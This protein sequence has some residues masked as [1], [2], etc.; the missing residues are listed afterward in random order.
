MSTH[1]AAG[2]RP[3]IITLQQHLAAGKFLGD[4]AVPTGADLR[5][6]F[7]DALQLVAGLRLNL[8]TTD[9][10]RLALL[11]ASA[12]QE[13]SHEATRMELTA[14]DRACATA[15]HSLAQEELESLRCS[16]ADTSVEPARARGRNSYKNPAELL[17]AWTGNSYGMMHRAVLDAQD[18]IGRRS[19][20]GAPLPARF[21]HLAAKF[22]DPEVNPATV[23]LI[24]AKLAKAEPKD[25]TFDGIRTEPTL[26][27][28]DGKTV[29]EH[30]AR[31]L[32]EEFTQAAALKAVGNLITEATTGNDRGDPPPR[33]RRGLFPLPITSPYER[34]Y[35]LCVSTLEGELI[36]SFR[37]HASNPRTQ[38][39]QAARKNPDSARPAA[40]GSPD[41]PSSDAPGDVLGNSILDLLPE[42]QNTRWE[43]DEQFVDEAAPVERAVNALLD[44][45]QFEYFDDCSY[46][47]TD[48]AA[49]S[50]QDPLFGWQ[51]PA[52]KPDGP[53]APPAGPPADPGRHR[54][55]LRP[56]LIVHLM[57]E[58]LRNIASSRAETQNG[59]VLAPSA[60]RRMLCDADVIPAV[61]NSKGSLLDYGRAVRLVPEALQKAVLARDRYCIVPGCTAPVE[62]L[63]FHHIKPFSHGGKTCAQ[64]TVPGCGT[65]HM[66]MDLGLIQV[67]WE[68]GLPWVLLP[69]DR[70]PQQ[71]LR[72]NYCPD[73]I[74]KQLK[75][76]KQR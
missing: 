72:R 52:H 30:A 3:A 6:L 20:S 22:A 5:A 16:P 62:Q 56:Q 53:P 32:E 2:L 10:P 47:D 45:L 75:P 38:A 58:D 7:T 28:A 18:L 29:E 40:G 66:E 31:A 9:D 48:G 51:D 63:Q 8:S 73:G 69:K 15:A 12:A 4:D 23:R 55:R 19:P 67:Q 13:L 54:R 35:L 24:S 42:G 60:L 17:A 71:L 46:S 64:N 65:H 25:R 44:L 59:T 26:R 74:P 11:L 39:G 34:R 14:A 68:Q 36:D 70:D 1:H 27:H 43:D 37:A 21:T 41:Q 33:I 49:P 50:G 61:F 57:V 76:R